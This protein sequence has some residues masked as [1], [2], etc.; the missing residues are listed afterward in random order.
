[1]SSKTLLSLNG[2]LHTQNGAQAIHCCGASS[3]V[4]DAPVGF[5]VPADSPDHVNIWY[6]RSVGEGA[7]EYLSLKSIA[8][9]R[10]CS[11]NS[12]AVRNAVRLTGT[13]G[14]LYV[15][16][17]KSQETALAAADT[18]RNLAGEYLQANREA[19]EK[20]GLTDD[21]QESAVQVTQPQVDP[22][23]K[24]AQRKHRFLHGLGITLQTIGYLF[25]I[26]MFGA[27]ANDNGSTNWDGAI[28]GALAMAAF[29]AV[30]VTLTKKF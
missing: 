25:L 19:A 10:A 28:L 11:V 21:P 6:L 1:M 3:D 27:L 17:L 9:I 23:A 18:L 24:A 20:L 29:I 26:A 13:N 22:A 30:G 8:D 2:K 7:T 16:R 12:D 14:E 4:K 5:S 15:L